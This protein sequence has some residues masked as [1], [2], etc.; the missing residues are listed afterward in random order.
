MPSTSIERRG[1]RPVRAG[2]QIHPQQ[3]NYVRRA[4]ARW[5]WLSVPAI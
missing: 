4:L 2:A 3:A 1:L 5:S